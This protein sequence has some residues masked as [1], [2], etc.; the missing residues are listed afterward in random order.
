MSCVLVKLL[1]SLLKYQRVSCDFQVTDTQLCFF[2]RNVL[3]KI[4]C[5]NGS[6]LYCFSDYLSV[7]QFALARIVIIYVDGTLKQSKF[8]EYTLP[9]RLTVNGLNY[10]SKCEVNDYLCCMYRRSLSPIVLRPSP[11]SGVKRRGIVCY[12]VVLNINVIEYYIVKYY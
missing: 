4:G 3:W 10:S 1:N 9:T 7:I 12:F 6:Q 5:H 11:L 8:I 2:V